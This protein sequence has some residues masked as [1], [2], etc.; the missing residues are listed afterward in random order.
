M[1][2]QREAFEKWMFSNKID[3][4]ESYCTELMYKAWQAAL[5]QEATREPV[6]EVRCRNGKWFGYIPVSV[7]NAKKVEAGMKLYTEAIPN[8]DAEKIRIG[9]RETCAKV[10]ES[11][12]L[13]CTKAHHAY[14]SSDDSKAMAW[15]ISFAIRNQPSNGSE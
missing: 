3:H 15:D 4:D 6:G 11:M 8:K 7:L 13:Q 9:E 2:K 12:P 5:S 14:R 10:A 1:D